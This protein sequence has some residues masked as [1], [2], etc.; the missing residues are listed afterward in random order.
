M[1][2]SSRR[3]RMYLAEN[4]IIFENF[5]CSLYWGG[6]KSNRW[7]GAFF[8][9]AV[10]S[11]GLISTM[12]VSK[13]LLINL[14]ITLNMRREGISANLKAIFGELLECTSTLLVIIKT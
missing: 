14:K 6:D 3:A 9:S 1:M 2:Y 5:N 4:Y 7:L 8:L 13:S 10:Q 12:N 11:I